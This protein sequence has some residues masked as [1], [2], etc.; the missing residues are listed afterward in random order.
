[1]I[2]LKRF[3]AVQDGRKYLR[4]PFSA[5]GGTAASNGFIVVWADQASDAPA[6]DC[7][8]KMIAKAKAEAGDPDAQWIEVS[9]IRMS[10]KECPECDGTGRVEI[11]ECPECDG[12]GEFDHGSHTYSC[13]ECGG[14]GEIVATGSGA[15]CE[16]CGGT[17]KSLAGCASSYGAVSDTGSPYGYTISS[18]FVERMR[19]L[20]GCMVRTYTRPP[21]DGIAF[22][23]AGGCGVVMPLAVNPIP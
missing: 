17:G 19:E 21:R 5:M 20:P 15:L 13:K 23:F 2:D 18:H 6:H 3:C 10:S 4:A 1:M 8:D 11:E 7:A 14:G 16:E 9:T 12:C 22:K